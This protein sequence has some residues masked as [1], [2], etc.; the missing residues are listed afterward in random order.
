[1]KGSEI[2]GREDFEEIY[3]GGIKSFIGKILGFG[4]TK[5]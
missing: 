3:F 4:G 5:L 2:G 1:V